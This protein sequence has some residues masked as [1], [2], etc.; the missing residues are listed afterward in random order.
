MSFLK[1]FFDIRKNEAGRAASM[2]LFFFCV[3]AAFWILKPLRTSSIFKTLGPLSYP[4]TKFGTALILVPVVIAYSTLAVR[5]GRRQIL[6]L[7]GIVFSIGFGAAYFWFYRGP[8]AA[9]LVAFFFL[10]D[11]F[12]TVMVALFWT[13]LNDMSGPE[14]A[15]R[16]YGLIG[17]G[18]LAGGLAGSSISGWAVPWLS[19][20][21]LILAAGVLFLAGAFIVGFLLNGSHR[22]GSGG[23]SP[24]PV[25]DWKNAGRGMSTVLK[26]PYLLGI[27]GIVIFYETASTVVDFQFNA[28]SSEVHP[29]VMSMASYQGKVASVAIAAGLIVQL[30]FTSFTMR[31]AGVVTALL[32]LPVI[33]L[34]GSAGLAVG[35]DLAAG[36][37]LFAADGSLHYSINQTSKEVLYT[38]LDRKQIFRG[39][40]FIDMFTFRAA[41]GL[42]SLVLLAILYLLKLSGRDPGFPLSVLNMLIILVWIWI[43]VMTARKY[44]EMTG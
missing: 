15:K 13:I 6:W 17:T 30:F 2:F 5:L 7:S 28:Y 33:L 12:N 18:G 26:S 39:K 19:E 9:E 42:S 44:R 36:T 23:D 16:L 35:G 25:E 11:V 24:S 20:C 32:V 31:R 10:V 41:K 8:T 40:A 22:S 29:T 38:P 14:Q 43:A 4:A 1:S 34:A 21:D 3:I 27:A 37:L